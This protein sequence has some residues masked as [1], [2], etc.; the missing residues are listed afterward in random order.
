M[1]QMRE[2]TQAGICNALDIFVIN[3]CLFK[4]LIKDIGQKN[5]VK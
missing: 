1:K 3:L 5:I 4:Y 2:K